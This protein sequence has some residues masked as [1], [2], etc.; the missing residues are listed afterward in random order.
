MLHPRGAAGVGGTGGLCRDLF[1]GPQQRALPLPQPGL[2]K[3]RVHSWLLA[4]FLT[5]VH[6]PWRPPLRVRLGGA[7]RLSTQSSA[8][9]ASARAPSEE[10]QPGVGDSHSSGLC[11]PGARAPGGAVTQ[12]G[13]VGALGCHLPFPLYVTQMASPPAPWFSLTGTRTTLPSGVGRRLPA[14][15]S[16]QPASDLQ[17]DHCLTPV[18][19]RQIQSLENLRT[20]LSCAMGQ[21]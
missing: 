3:V 2:P 21:S 9:L 19:G 4:P 17:S 20:R 13:S 1:L 8:T 6:S 18:R 14:A 11:C 7:E 15:H 12:A 10:T 16:V 5:Q